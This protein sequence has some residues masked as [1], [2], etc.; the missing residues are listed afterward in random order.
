MQNRAVPVPE[1]AA[2]DPQRH[3][4]FVQLF[5]RSGSQAGAEQAVHR[6]T[7]VPTQAATP[8]S[9]QHSWLFVH[10]RASL[11]SHAPHCPFWEP[12]R[13]HV[14]LPPAFNAHRRSATSAIGVLASHAAHTLLTQNGAFAFAVQSLSSTQATQRP[15][16]ASQTG[17]PG[18]LAQCPSFLHPWHEKRP[19]ASPR[20]SGFVGSVQPAS[21]L[22][23]QLL[24]VRSTQYASLGPAAHSALLAQ[25]RHWVVAVSQMGDV[26]ELQSAGFAQLPQAPLAVHTRG[27]GQSSGEVVHGLHVWVTASQM[28]VFPVQPALFWVGSHRAH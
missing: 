6:V 19:V 7:L 12:P 16:A 28:G 13:T 18:R 25:G 5:E 8:A 14:G 2:F 20:Q 26:A 17:A 15:V 24:Q 11:G 22:G 10:P 21:V 23:L 27:F 1:H 9:S 4:R 3:A